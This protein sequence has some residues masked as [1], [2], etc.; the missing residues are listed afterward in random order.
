MAQQSNFSSLCRGHLLPKGITPK[1][2]IMKFKD[3]INLTQVKKVYVHEHTK[4]NGTKKHT[5]YR[6]TSNTSDCKKIILFLQDTL[7]NSKFI[8]VLLYH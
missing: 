4:S 5:H 3:S 7:T 1:D 6:F 2:K 8:R